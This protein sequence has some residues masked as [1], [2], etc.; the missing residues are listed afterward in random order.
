MST[1]YD[2]LVEIA[3]LPACAGVVAVVTAGAKC[4][5]GAAPAGSGAG[6]AFVF[7]VF[8]IVVQV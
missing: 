3:A 4:V 7:G 6:V 1:L 2:H 5:A 8:A